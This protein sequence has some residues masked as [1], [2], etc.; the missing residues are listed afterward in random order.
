MESVLQENSALPEPQ[1][2]WDMA[3]IT[4][5]PK[6]NGLFTALQIDEEIPLL[7]QTVTPPVSPKDYISKD[8]I[9]EIWKE[10]DEEAE[11]DRQVQ[12][13]ATALARTP[14]RNPFSDSR[15]SGDYQQLDG[16]F[17][18][19]ISLVEKM[20]SP[21]G[22][23]SP[24]ATSTRTGRAY[25][26]LKRFDP[27]KPI[28]IQISDSE[29]RLTK[30]EAYLPQDNPGVISA[31]EQLAKLHLEVGTSK[32]AEALFL[33]VA[34][35][36][37]RILGTE[38]PETVSVY[39]SIVAAMEHAGEHSEA[40]KLHKKL[41]A[42]ILEIFG[43][44][45]ELGITSIAL[46]GGVHYHNDRPREAEDH[47]RQS[48]QLALNTLGKHHPLI[49]EI[50]A[51]LGVN[52]YVNN[53]NDIGVA[54]RLVRE[55]FEV[56][57]ALHGGPENVPLHHFGGLAWIL[58]LAGRKDESIQLHRMQVARSWKV[59]G[60]DHWATRFNLRRLSKALRFNND[61]VTA[62]PKSKLALLESIQAV[63]VDHRQ[64]IDC[65]EEVAMVLLAMGEWRE[66]AVKYE[67]VYVSRVKTHGVD[68]AGTRISRDA[69]RECYS[70]QGLYTEAHQMEERLYWLRHN[71]IIPKAE[72]EVRQ[73]SRYDMDLEDDER[74]SRAS[75]RMRSR[76]SMEADQ[77]EIAEYKTGFIPPDA[78]K[79]RAPAQD[80][81]SMEDPE[82]EE[83]ASIECVDEESSEDDDS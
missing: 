29:T 60:M 71:L 14:D 39:L 45:S 36:K 4:G 35:A 41:H 18:Q 65:I 72:K 13:H 59:E 31:A 69:L 22:E 8:E 24:F 83:E 67:Q 7:P 53:K 32:R 74:E 82:T 38:H 57:C 3:N 54:E 19:W 76:E 37:Q 55:G 52:L 75:K 77:A 80:V 21:L 10:A 20:I 61:L 12:A 11:N 70:M 47:Q 50:L 44:Q 68:T 33:R 1:T 46:M 62:E 58:P 49:P 78:S 43:P 73:W 30:L 34:L 9:A 79:L 48:L 66:A 64:T 16:Y 40:E 2:L 5:S 23:I 15:G 27:R 6:L 56:D 63:G 25:S 26:A 81:E 51:D 42:R 17:R 28:S